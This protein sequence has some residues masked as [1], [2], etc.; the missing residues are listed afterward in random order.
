MLEFVCALRQCLSVPWKCR[1]KVSNFGRRRLCFLWHN[2]HRSR[3][4][5]VFGFM[6]FSREQREPGGGKRTRTT[7]KLLVTSGKKF[8]LVKGTRLATLDEPGLSYLRH[9]R[10]LAAAQ[11]RRGA[12]GGHN[13]TTSGKHHRSSWAYR[14]YNFL[15]IV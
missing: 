8:A 7:A 9:Q 15:Y 10:F 12:L 11:L 14:L 5:G 13:K 4:A 1:A 3:R 6:F 2:S